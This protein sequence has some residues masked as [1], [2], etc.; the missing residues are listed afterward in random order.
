MFSH[1]FLT[2]CITF[3]LA[4]AAKAQS[5]EEIA[6]YEEE[7]VKAN[8]EKQRDAEESLYK[9]THPILTQSGA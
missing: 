7:K 2:F 9:G 3:A 5:A 4:A 8:E 6:T 1:M